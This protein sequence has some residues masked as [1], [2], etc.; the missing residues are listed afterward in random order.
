MNV[1]LAGSSDRQLE[2][3]LRTIGV[4]IVAVPSTDLEAVAP[5]ATLHADVLILD[6][7]QASQLPSSLPIFRR[8]HPSTDIILVASSLDPT[9][10]LEAM[11]SGVSEVVTDPITQSDLEAALAR[12]VG[13]RVAPISG[14][15]FAFLGA[16]GGVGTTTVAVNVAAA[17]AK[18]T[19]QAPL[20]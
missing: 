9:L 13:Q 15:V 7:R 11:R 4:S 3:Y 20:L 1:I 8:Q 10:M 18:M 5:A 14:Q 19:S 16:K 17:L 12:V 6:I 2:G